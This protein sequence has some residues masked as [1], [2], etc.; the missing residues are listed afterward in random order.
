MRRD[1][2]VVLMRLFSPALL[3]AALLAPSLFAQQ[4]V[5]LTVGVLTGPFR[6]ATS[7][8]ILNLSETAAFQANFGRVVRT[9]K[10]ADM[11]GEVHFLASP[12][13]TVTSTV[14]SATK[15]FSSLFL[16]PGVRFKFYPKKLLSPWVVVGGGYAHFLQSDKTIA[17]AANLA[18]RHRSTPAVAY[19]AGL[20]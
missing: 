11:Y 10:Y 15:S 16:T 14:T 9:Y 17:G 13:T 18:Q 4:E 19:G 1:A 2:T 5:G 20:D 3:F 12:G 8:A 7:G 6:T